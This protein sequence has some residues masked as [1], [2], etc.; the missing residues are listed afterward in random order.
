MNTETALALLDVGV[1]P[2]KGAVVFLLT[3]GI[4]H[5]FERCALRLA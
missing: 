2:A 5:T 1:E 3:L 4:E